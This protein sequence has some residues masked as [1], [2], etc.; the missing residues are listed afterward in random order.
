[1]GN[2]SFLPSK[3]SSLL[4]S[5]PLQSHTKYSTLATSEIT[6]LHL[7]LLDYVVGDYWVDCGIRATAKPQAC[8]PWELLS[9]V[10]FT[11]AVPCQSSPLR[12]VCPFHVACLLSLVW[13]K[14][15]SEARTCTI[16]NCSHLLSAFPHSTIEKRKN[17]TSRKQIPFETATV[18]LKIVSNHS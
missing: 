10:E 18:L 17:N 15:E 5:P 9:W 12:Y 11:I 4:V 7:T 1:M 16:R 14:V 6:S 2:H 8:N 3:P 13:P